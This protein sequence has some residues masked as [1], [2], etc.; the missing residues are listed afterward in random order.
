MGNLNV[1]CADGKAGEN[2]P[3]PFEKTLPTAYCN[4][5]KTINTNRC[6]RWLTRGKTIH[7]KVSHRLFTNWALTSPTTKSLGEDSSNNRTV[8]DNAKLLAR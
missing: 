5:T 7:R 3:I 8:I 2:D 6:E 1:Y 4:G